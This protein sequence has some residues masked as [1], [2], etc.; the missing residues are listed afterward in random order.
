[1]EN[2]VVNL[3]NGLHPEFD[4]HVACLTKRGAFVE[5]L[6]PWS[7]VVSLGKKNRASVLVVWRL[8][9]H[10]L[11]SQPDVLHTHNLGPLVY[12]SLATGFGRC[13]SIVHGEHSLLTNEEK[14]PRRLVQRRKL[15]RFCRV[16]HCVA[17]VIREEL[18]T[19]KCIHPALCVVP[20]GVDTVRFSPGGRT[21]TRTRFGLPKDAPVLGIVGR[22][23]PHKGHIALI[24]AFGTLPRQY[25]LLVV[26]GGGSEEEKVRIA[27]ARSPSARRIHFAGFLSDP[28]SAYRALDLLVI[29]STNEG[30]ANVALEAMACEVPIL[31]NVGC[32]HE[33]M[34]Q[35]G[36]DGVIADLQHSVGLAAEIRS[37]LDAPFASIEMGRRAR[38]KVSERFS[39]EA[40]IR[41]YADIYRS[42]KKAGM[43]ARS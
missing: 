34:I 30:M 16:V 15:Y 2:G 43:T 37:L 17:P 11:V 33:A 5:R 19:L 40:M 20:N 10:L 6:P 7:K 42:L 36:Y 9:R 35:T 8:I 12:A 21:E 32:G 41:K 24:E 22:F 23:G 29:P 31:G 28:V 3:I 39:L 18:L 1:M 26:G 13:F 25:H 27:A 14:S 4:G 38:A